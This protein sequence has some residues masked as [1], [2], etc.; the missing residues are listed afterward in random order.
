VFA[1]D[2]RELDAAHIRDLTGEALPAGELDV[3]DGSPPCQGFS[4]A[5]QREV[6]DERNF[7]FVEYVRLLAEL[8]PRTFVM[9]NVSG[10]LRG[11]HRWV[12]GE[13]WKRLEAAGYVVAAKLLDA[14]LLGVPQ[15]RLRVIFV[16][17]RRDLELNPV[18]PDPLPGPRPTL[19]EAF[20]GLPED[21]SRSVGDLGIALWRRTPPGESFA[22]RHPR[23][24]W[25]SHV[26][27]HPNRPA[28]TL[29][30]TTNL[31]HWSY[32][33]FLNEAEI[34]RVSSFPDDF[35]VN[36][37]LVKTWARFGNAVPP[38]MMQAVA[39]KLRDEVLAA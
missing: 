30:K 25:F 28:N 32:P 19:G 26:K 17:V 23:G 36:G 22:S 9:E 1:G 7:L 10:M 6:F 2:V 18:H 21:R 8:Q 3:L 4:M 37:G 20:V 24:Q 5:G 12:F 35:V 34:R 14:S 11:Q 27:C 39:A 29:T 38:K 15:R 31:Y 16:G 33:R 13:I